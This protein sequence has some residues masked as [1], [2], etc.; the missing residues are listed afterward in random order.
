[1]LFRRNPAAGLGTWLPFAL[2]TLLGAFLVFQVQPVISKA[3][4]PWF[5][6]SPAVWTT[7]ML[8]FQVVLF[9][10]YLYAHFLST[11][12]S[13]R[14]QA[15][16]HAALLVLA[17]AS[18]PINPGEAWE[19]Q[20]N[21]SPV[22]YLL[23]L[24]TVHVG[25]PYFV[26][27]STGPLVQAWMSYRIAGSGVYRL[28]ALSNVGSLTALLTY[29][30]LV[31][32][33]LAIETQSLVWSLMFCLFVLVQAVLVWRML[34][35]PHVSTGEPT[36]ASEPSGSAPPSARPSA[37]SATPPAPSA[38]RRAAWLLLPAFASVMLLAVTNHI[39]QEVAVIP[40]LWVLPLSFYLL[41]F[42][43][44][45]DRPTWYRPKLYAAAAVATVGFVSLLSIG[46]WVGWMVGQAVGY[47]LLLFVVCLLCHGELARL[48][49][50]PAY[51]TQYYVLLS[52]GGAVGGICVA[53][54]CPLLFSSY[55]EMSFGLATSAMLAFGLFMGYRHWGPSPQDADFDWSGV[56]RFSWTGG[57]LCLGLLG[58]VG[59]HDSRDEIAS[60][61]NFF[62]V[63]RIKELD[64]R[65]SMVHGSTVHG[66]QNPAPHAGVP[67]TYYTPDSGLGRVI[68][69]LGRRGPLRI[70]AVGLGCGTLAAYGRP[71]DSIDFIEINPSVIALAKAH[72]SFL[73]DSPADVELL[74][75]DGRLVLGRQP[76]ASYDLLV[77]DAFSSDAVPAHLLTREALGV[78]RQ[79]LGAGGAMAFHVSNKHLD[80]APIVHRLAEEIDC[81]SRLYRVAGDPREAKRASFWV[82]LSPDPALWQDPLMEGGQTMAPRRLQETPLWTDQYHDLFSV[83]RL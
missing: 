52:A 5:G 9:A 71:G 36:S 28:Y 19:P 80:L 38:R 3:V 42:V 65:V 59:W 31:E 47:L 15:M 24:L 6:G 30:F 26:L 68:R 77:L 62:G 14:G 72:F 20:G 34:R 82:V 78:Y 51:L 79:R 60:H 76:P 33:V 53:L 8:F 12:F 23:G 1:M 22:F 49:P 48:K 17:V 35:S 10:G 27:S 69:A 4:L 32:P 56:G 18:L 73:R 41:S 70:G 45:F 7:C 13:P 54:I 57:L 2:A 58:L 61:R 25:L 16:L 44:C 29:P 63:L 74:L 64:G 40:F 50:A 11:R 81:Q 21:E 39:C 43:L 66:C 55:V 46:P 75:G 37:A 83:M 67:T